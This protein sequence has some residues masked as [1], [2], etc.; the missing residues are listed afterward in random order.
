M[1]FLHQCTKHIMSGATCCDVRSL[2]VFVRHVAACN[3][4][5][6]ITCH[7][8]GE[9][10]SNNTCAFC[11]RALSVNAS[12][13]HPFKLDTIYTPPTPSVQSQ[14]Q[15]RTCIMCNG[16]D[17]QTV[18]PGATVY[19]S[20]NC[21]HLADNL[22][23]TL[24]NSQPASLNN[25]TL[26]LHANATLKG[27]PIT[28]SSALHIDPHTDNSQLTIAMNGSAI[29]NDMCAFSVVNGLR[30]NRVDVS[31]AANILFESSQQ[32]LLGVFPMSGGKTL[33][34][35]IHVGQV[36]FASHA[37]MPRYAA[38]IANVNGNVHS[39]SL[40]AVLYFETGAGMLSVIAPPNATIIALSALLNL[41][42][43]TYEIEFYNPTGAAK[44]APRMPWL[45]KT[46]RM[47]VVAALILAGALLST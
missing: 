24:Y 29:D 28:V 16:G 17:L 14:C 8:I 1:H 47:L 20:S 25:I 35:D 11:T 13:A 38:A 37:D 31:I 44:V 4:L 5:C 22:A 33:Q 26:K 15:G 3:M 7:S 39:S 21:N 2:H 27:Y 41:F 6:G 36:T 32:C 42:G 34:G 10:Q 9:L 19:T 12:C 45:P 43:T 30:N 40:N 23:V 18:P 46:N